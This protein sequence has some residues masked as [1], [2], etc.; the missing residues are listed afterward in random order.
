LALVLI[1]GVCTRFATPNAR[2]FPT[3]YNCDGDGDGGGKGDGG[4]DGDGDGDD[5]AKS[6][7][8]N[9]IQTQK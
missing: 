9:H 8:Q 6:N 2:A 5:D 4:L 7:T 3:L 1:F